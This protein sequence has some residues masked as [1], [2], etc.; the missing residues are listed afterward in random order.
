ML[1]LEARGIHET[2]CVWYSFISPANANAFHSFN[3]IMKCDIDIRPHLYGNV[4]VS[5]GNTMFPGFADRMYK[6]LDA[7]APSKIRVIPNSVTLSSF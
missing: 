2:V 5:G 6:E 1:G 7:F 4:V 3:S